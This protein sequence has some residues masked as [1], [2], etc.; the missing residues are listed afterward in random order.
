M[1]VGWVVST[2]GMV[3]GMG[4]GERSTRDS[5]GGERQ[6]GEECGPVRRQGRGWRGGLRMVG[7]VERLS[8]TGQGGGSGWRECSRGGMHMVQGL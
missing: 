2:M 8:G 5:L 7:L 6:V 3:A 4:R 1:V